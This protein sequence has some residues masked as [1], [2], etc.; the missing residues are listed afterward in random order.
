[1]R[2]P[3]KCQQQPKLDSPF[4]DTLDQMTR[5]QLRQHGGASD[6]APVIESVLPA[7]SGS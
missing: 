4:T 6:D 3:W 5:P 7:E 2:L 1:V